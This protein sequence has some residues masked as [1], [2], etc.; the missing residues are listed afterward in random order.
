LSGE[1]LPPS[2]VTV[3]APAAPDNQPDSSHRRN[4]R[5]AA[6]A[7]V[8]LALIWGYAWVVM[9]IALDYAQPFTFAA[10][11]T[12]FGAIALF[13]VLPVMR[14][15]LRPK[16]LKLTA[17]LGVMQTAGFVGL[18]TLALVN[19]GAGKTSILT[20]TMPFW[21]LLMAWVFLGERLKGFQWVAVGLA[22]CGMILLL[23]PWRFHEGWSG[24]IAV[25]GAIVWAGSAIVAKILRKRHEVDLFSMTAWQMLLGSLILVVLAA[26][27]WSGPPIWTGTFVAALV[28]VVI[29]GNT[30][31]WLLWLYILHA[32]PAG[33]AG[34]GTLLTPVIGISS[35]WIQLGERPS[36][37]EGLGMIAI[38]S[39]LLITVLWEIARERR[40][41]AA[42]YRELKPRN[43]LG[44]NGSAGRQ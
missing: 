35:A 11:R 19:G 7:L 20:Y 8:L 42:A 18:L 1:A 38:V 17:L 10:M 24:V 33:T 21:L 28:Y 31:A 15:P 40:K 37:A 22:I 30:V 4:I 9:K 39:A 32:L 36:L 25:C 34:L 13:L 16:A 6:A 44:R 27:T 29:F 3:P 14:R 23:T 41:R 5:L 26:V 43:I 12:F 2:E